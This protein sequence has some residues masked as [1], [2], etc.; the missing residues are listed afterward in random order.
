MPCTKVVVYLQALKYVLPCTCK[1]GFTTQQVTTD[2]YSYRHE[3]VNSKCMFILVSIDPNK[4][5]VDTRYIKWGIQLYSFE[6]ADDHFIRR[7]RCYMK[8][9]AEL[10]RKRGEVAVLY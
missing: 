4:A 1:A 6:F 8:L 9:P 3:R 7:H 5:F 2:R 10:G